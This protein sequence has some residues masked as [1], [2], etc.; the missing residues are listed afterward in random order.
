MHASYLLKRHCKIEENN[1]YRRSLD[2]LSMLRLKN[3]SKGPL[4]SISLTLTKAAYQKL[5]CAFLAYAFVL[6]QKHNI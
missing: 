6:L 5:H 1:S 3:K 4:D 2:N